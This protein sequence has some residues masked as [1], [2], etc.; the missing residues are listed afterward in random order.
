L[1]L[2]ELKKGEEALV[3]NY[4]GAY[5]EDIKVGQIIT[6]DHLDGEH[7]CAKF[8]D[9]Q[10]TAVFRREYLLAIGDKV[11]DTS[12]KHKWSGE[13]G[14]VEIIRDRSITVKWPVYGSG[15]HATGI[16][17]DTIRHA[18]H[19]DL[20]PTG[21]SEAQED[22]G[23][24]DCF[25]EDGNCHRTWVDEPHGETK[26]CEWTSKCH[27]AY[28]RKRPGRLLHPE[29]LGQ[30]KSKPKCF[31]RWT[32]HGHSC[33]TCPNISFSKEVRCGCTIGHCVYAQDCHDKHYREESSEP[34]HK[35][36]AQWGASPHML[37][38]AAYDYIMREG[39]WN[40]AE[41]FNRLERAKE[42]EMV[43]L[44]KAKNQTKSA[45][46]KEVLLKEEMERLTTFP[47]EYAEKEF[48]LQKLVGKERAKE[49]MR[50]IE[51]GLPVTV[52]IEEQK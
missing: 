46:E 52:N 12:G 20:K 17:M 50:C 1:E 48:L 3:L 33:A 38:R 43:E 25:G 11:I 19:Q 2:R 32:C 26:E 31:G 42:I 9:N 4:G 41:T 5:T 22:E 15:V 49:T 13:I 30:S 16:S 44:P 29:T 7:W 51:L 34:K 47:T 8:G 27:A 40:M 37:Q 36:D 24:P 18:D 14:V 10:Y 23:K 45:Q 21:E 6:I 39:D 35:G 28:H